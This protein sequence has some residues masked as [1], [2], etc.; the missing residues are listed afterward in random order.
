M[1]DH[2]TIT[3]LTWHLLWLLLCWTTWNSFS[4]DWWQF[5]LISELKFPGFF[6]HVIRFFIVTFFL[7]SPGSGNFSQL[8]ST[9]QISLPYSAMVRSELNLPLEATFMIAIL[10]HKSW[11]WN[12]DKRKSNIQ[13]EPGWEFTKLLRQIRQIFCKFKVLL[14]SS[15]S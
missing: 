13:K 7:Y 12:D 4:M 9:P 15:Y 6:P 3:S 1:N 11:F 5:N 14:W 10:A 2:F 8:G